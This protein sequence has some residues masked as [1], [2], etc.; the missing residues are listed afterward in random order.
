MLGNKTTS[1]QSHLQR[2]AVV[3]AH[4]LAHQW[5]GDL[6]TM[7]WWSSLWLNEGFATF[8]EYRGANHFDSSFQ[9]LDQF[10]PTDPQAAM[11]VD[12][13]GSSHAL[14][15]TD[16]QS[17]AQIE[18]MF[19]G[20]SYSK[21]ASVISMVESYLGTDT[22]NN[23]IAAY[24]RAHAYG[25]AGPNDLWSALGEAAAD[26][27]LAKDMPEWN[28]Q[29]GFPLISLKWSD[30]SK[31]ALSASQSRFFS[32]QYSKQVAQHAGVANVDWWV[33]FTYFSQ[34]NNDTKRMAFSGATA[35]DTVPAPAAGQWVKGNAD[36]AGYYRVN[37]PV[38]IWEAFR[39]YL[40]DNAPTADA[41]TAN[42]RSGLLSDLKA[43][44][45]SNA[46]EE[47]VGA[48]VN[49][50]LLMRFAN[51]LRTESTWTVWTPGT[52]LLST[53]NSYL[54][55]DDAAPTGDAKACHNNFN[56]FA[57]E[58]LTPIVTAVGWDATPVNGA[59]EPPIR[60]LLRTRVLSAAVSF[61]QVSATQ[62]AEARYL[63]WKG[64]DKTV[65]TADTLAV[66]LKAAVQ[67]NVGG[68]AWEEM[69]NIYKNNGNDA[70]LL[71]QASGA[72]ASS[73][74]T[75]ELQM[76]LEF[77]LSDDVRGQDSVSIVTAVAGNPAGRKLAWAFFKANYA[78]FM[79]RYGQGGFALSNLVKGVASHFVSKDML[80]EVTAYFADTPVE[81]A[82]TEVSQ[83]IEAINAHA[84]FLQSQG[85]MVCDWLAE[86]V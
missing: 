51:M 42:D 9:M 67:N 49:A 43:I 54:H 50:T 21:G 37:Y 31:N 64:G 47:E 75:T 63:A 83:A 24:L 40:V 60:T 27:A 32:G 57:A 74:N 25:N 28:M 48:G 56:A 65:L 41:L 86:N 23:G 15:R 52:G 73:K 82:A 29:P 59:P 10:V 33:P 46:P 55:G 39:S 34:S 11:A 4:E 3:V 80:Q 76:T 30:A 2:I 69:K 72:M 79:Q 81:A 1:A 61:N 20:I 85:G 22:F 45:L 7:D 14:T 38:E 84:D 78:T 17:P 19:D 58:L 16:V 36:T 68:N 70:T 77:A 18:E 35:A 26:D 5:F 8:T 62:E 13:F 53:F 71:R 66:A 6:V 12:A 44:V